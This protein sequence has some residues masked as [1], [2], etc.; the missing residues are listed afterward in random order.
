[1]GVIARLAEA[2]FLDVKRVKAWLAIAAAFTVAAVVAGILLAKDGRDPLGRPL[3]TDFLAFWTAARVAIADGA[4]AVWDGIRLQA[5]QVATFGQSDAFTAFFYPPIFLLIVL[6]LGL[7]PHGAALALWLAGTGLAAARG[8]FAQA[9][10]T[11]DARTAILALLAFPAT[12][13]TLGHGQNAFLATAL[14]AFAAARL[15]ARPLLAGALLGALAFK[16]QL[17]VAV[18]FVLIAGGRLRALAAT[19]A[20][21]LG[22]AAIATIA[23]GVEAWRAFLAMSEVA[24]ATLDLGLVEAA[25]MVSPYAAA[26]VLGASNAT[27]AAL[28][29]AVSIG[30]LAV[31]AFAARRTSGE[32][33]VALA[34]AAVP[35]AGPF[36]LDYDLMV[37]AVPM[38]F[39]V[40]EGVR[41]GF[42]PHE[43]IGLL[44][45]FVLPAAARPLATM[46]HLPVAPLV[47]TVLLAL[48]VRRARSTGRDDAIRPL[49]PRESDAPSA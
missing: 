21:A 19:V 24:R 45:A 3:G 49:L 9:R 18:P 17:A 38:V 48:V 10:G 36:V 42:A 8:L 6:P 40:G 22:L 27:A 41:G 13:A 31:V 25:K 30:V 29:L 28:Q 44:A 16:P 5:E 7:L 14:F 12:F 39:L 35:L 11:I 33:T 2:K 32:A 34:V 46:F 47:A 26:R 1:M 4:P 43:K 37:L 15:D 20:A 23:F